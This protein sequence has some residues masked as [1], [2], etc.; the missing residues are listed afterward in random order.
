[1]PPLKWERDKNQHINHQFT[2]T[3]VC[4]DTLLKTKALTTWPYTPNIMVTTHL[5]SGIPLGVL[6]P[7]PAT[8]TTFFTDSVCSSPATSDICLTTPFVPA[9]PDNTLLQTITNNTLITYLQLLNKTR[10]IK[11]HMCRLMIAN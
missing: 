9:R 7:A 5:K 10:V 2:D 11:D 3:F 4:L 6:M 1:M 8:I